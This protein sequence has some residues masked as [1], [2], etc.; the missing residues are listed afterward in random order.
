MTRGNHK[1]IVAMTE[2]EETLYTDFENKQYEDLR[3]K[4]EVIIHGTRFISQDD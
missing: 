4:K 2:K 3:Q 1:S